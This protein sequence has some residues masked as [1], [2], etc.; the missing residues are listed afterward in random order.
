MV[1]EVATMAVV[2]ITVVVEATMVGEVVT[3]A[4]EVETT[5]EEGMVT[6]A[7][8]RAIL[9][10]VAVLDPTAH[11]YRDSSR[12]MLVCLLQLLTPTTIAG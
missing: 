9:T 6:A 2:T 4:V 1:G 8:R 12:K 11:P 3:T 10:P 5:G 7:A